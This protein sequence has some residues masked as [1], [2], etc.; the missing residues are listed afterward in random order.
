MGDIKTAHD[1]E[2]RRAGIDLEKQLGRWPRR[3]LHVPSMTSYRWQ[4]GNIYGSTNCPEYN[5]LSYTWG[6]YCE[7]DKSS[8]IP[9][10]KIDNIDWSIPKVHKAHFD[11]QEL[12]TV[13]KMSTVESQGLECTEFLWI[14]IACIDQGGNVSSDLEIGRQAQ[15][16]RNAHRVYIWLGHTSAVRLREFQLFSSF[17]GTMKE[18]EE[19]TRYNQAALDEAHGL[20]EKLHEEPWFTSV[21]TLQEA[22][23]RKDA[24]LLSRDA[25]SIHISNASNIVIN[26][27]PI[28]NKS[29]AF[30]LR[31]FLVACDSVWLLCWAG[32]PNLKSENSVYLLKELGIVGMNRN[33]PMRLYATAASRKPKD[34]LDCIYGIQQIFD[35]RLGKSNPLH[36]R[37]NFTLKQLED[38][39]GEALMQINPVLSQNFVHTNSNLQIGKRWRLSCALENPALPFNYDTPWSYH[40]YEPRC[41]LGTNPVDD[42]LCGWFQGSTCDFVTLQQAWR[43]RHLEEPRSELLRQPIV[44]IQ[45]DVG[46]EIFMRIPAWRMGYSG[47]GAAADE[48]FALDLAEALAELANPEINFDCDGP[49]CLRIL[50]LGEHKSTQGECHLGLILF[51]SKHEP[52]EVW[53]RIGICAWLGPFSN[54]YGPIVDLQVPFAGLPHH[55]QPMCT[56]PDLDPVGQEIVQTA[57][58]SMV[59]S[60]KGHAWQAL[61]G[62][63][64]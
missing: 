29:E 45:L 14:D 59:L 64:G 8:N 37:D 39:L 43:T 49:Q 36:E 19:I 28:K 34:E 41:K 24:I 61:S 60:C 54:R 46:S 5:A 4:P 27:A 42:V 3:L 44:I 13:I 48:V 31:H 2:E 10:I 16:F 63:F 11:V 30:Q 15:I 33:D 51:Y 20:L 53:R 25:K 6:R 38:E 40:I 47:T 50:H 9:T 56:P 22:Y 35:L 55:G 1:N 26:S 57:E 17:W 21:W 32:L 62:N 12:E 58:L 18:S 7:T 52:R 23:L